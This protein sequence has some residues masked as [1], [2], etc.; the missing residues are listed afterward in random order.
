MPPYKIR[1]KLR[2]SEDAGED[3][4]SKWPMTPAERTR[5]CRQRQRQ[6]M[7]EDA[8]ATHRAAESKRVI[9]WRQKT[10]ETATG[11]VGLKQMQQ[12]SD[13]K[14]RHDITSQKKRWN[15]EKDRVRKAET[16]QKARNETERRGDI[17]PDAKEPESVPTSGSRT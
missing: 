9:A 15:R 13:R 12:S 4:S 6:A 16:R 7:T 1:V 3:T 5:L 14:R 17:S 10:N 2:N 8:L 11:R